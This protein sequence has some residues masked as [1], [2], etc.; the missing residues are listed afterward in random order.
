MTLGT[1]RRF[2]TISHEHVSML[3]RSD[4]GNDPLYFMLVE[5][6]DG[7]W[8]LE[9][10]FNDEEYDQFPDIYNDTL[11]REVVLYQNRLD[12]LMRALEIATVLRPTASKTEL[13]EE[14]DEE[15]KQAK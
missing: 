13:L 9:S 15:R 5:C 4:N 1:H 12:V 14:I 8:F 7:R 3:V 6:R 11:A 2:D 10:E